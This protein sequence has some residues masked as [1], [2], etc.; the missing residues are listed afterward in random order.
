MTNFTD[1]VLQKA[2]H[3]GHFHVCG[4]TMNFV[5]NGF[6]RKEIIAMGD[7]VY[8]MFVNGTMY[9]IGKAG[10][11]LGFAGRAQT[12]GQGR[13]KYGDATNRRIMDIMDDIP[14]DNIQVYA[15]PIPRRILTE[16]CP[17]TGE[18]FEIEVTLHKEYESRFTTMYLDEDTANSL[19]FCNQLT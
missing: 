5:R 4:D 19:P 15:L 8:F 13:G 12:Y 11:A 7:L 1:L 17:L 9:K 6:K 18:T 3:I 16:T 14:S 10:G 2:I